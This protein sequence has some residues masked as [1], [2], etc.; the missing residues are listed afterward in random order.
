M[1]DVSSN[2]SSPV[3]RFAARGDGLTED[4]RHI[5]GAVPG[6]RVAADGTIEAG[7][8]RQTPLCRHFGDCG[9]CQLQHATDALLADFAQARITEPL[10]RVVGAQPSE[11]VAMNSLTANLHF[12][13]V[14]FYR[15]SR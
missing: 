3:L 2:A 1:S 10:A 9:G 6:D 13:L 7:P 5:A 11:V 15:P 14:S 12:M 4:G 8:N